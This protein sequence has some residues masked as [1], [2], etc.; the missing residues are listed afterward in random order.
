MRRNERR[1]SRREGNGVRDEWRRGKET[2]RGDEK[3]ETRGRDEEL[4]R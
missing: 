3:M 2:G 1:L 4:R